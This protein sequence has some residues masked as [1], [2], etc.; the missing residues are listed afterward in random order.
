[1]PQN[2]QELLEVELQQELEVEQEQGLQE[3]ELQEVLKKYCRQQA[4]DHR[5]LVLPPHSLLV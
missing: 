1:V 5:L 2:Q 4:V 3:Q